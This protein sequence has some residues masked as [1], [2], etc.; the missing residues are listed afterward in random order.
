MY[1]LGNAYYSV[2]VGI[3][4]QKYLMFQFSGQ[5]HKFVCLTNGLISA[6][7]LFTKTMKPAFADLHKEGLSTWRNSVWGISM[8]NVKLLS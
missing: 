3:C 4:D 5:L 2:S 7:T 8:M 6:P 1:D